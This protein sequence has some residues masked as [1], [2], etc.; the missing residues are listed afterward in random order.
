MPY[1]TVAQAG[2]SKFSTDERISTVSYGATVQKLFESRAY[3][4]C[5]AD[6]VCRISVH[7]FDLDS[8][9]IQFA[10]LE[11]QL[12]PPFGVG[13]AEFKPNTVRGTKYWKEENA[14]SVDFDIFLIFH[15]LR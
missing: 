1:A 7:L 12:Q 10:L 5:E 6:L 9:G 14:I 11:Q 15:F 13:L 2:L 8:K 3:G 4:S